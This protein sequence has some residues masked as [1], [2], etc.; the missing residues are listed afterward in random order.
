MRVFLLTR[1]SPPVCFTNN[2]NKMYII[3]KWSWLPMPVLWNKI[4][5]HRMVVLS[6]Y[7]L[8]VCCLKKG[9]TLK[10]CTGFVVLD[11]CVFWS[12]F[13][14]TYFKKKKKLCS[15]IALSSIIY[16]RAITAKCSGPL[17]GTTLMRDNPCERPPLWLWEA[18]LVKEHPYQRQPLWKT[19]LMT[20]WEAT[21]VKEHP[22]QRQPLWK[23]TLM[24]LW[25]ATLVKEHPYQRQPLWK[26]TLMTLWETTPVKDWLY[27]YERPPL[28]KTNLM[29]DHPCE[30]PPL[31]LWETTPVKDHPMR[32]HPCERPPLWETTPVKD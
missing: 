28:W 10:V 7:Y 13:T 17:A 19:T 27:D 16:F 8:S 29:R 4:K 1:N 31:W 22:Y 12:C 14:D 21:L 5:T 24:T 26:S 23:T 6:C 3:L 2:N 20:L 30:R 32:D 9:F 25:E 11:S 18:T 15:M